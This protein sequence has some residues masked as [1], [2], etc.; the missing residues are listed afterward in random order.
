M[1]LLKLADILSTGWKRPVNG[2]S[3]IQPHQATRALKTSLQ[4]DKTRSYKKMMF[5][6][7][8]ILHRINMPS[9]EAQIITGGKD[10][11][12]PEYD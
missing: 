10:H 12:K 1:G 8:Q 6:I 5:L 11:D 4:L 9:Q 7:H 3:A 2:F